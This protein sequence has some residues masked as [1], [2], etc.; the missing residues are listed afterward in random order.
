[1]TKFIY[2][3]VKILNINN[4]SF[5]LNYIYLIHILFKDSENIYF[6]SR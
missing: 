3:N 2:N 4:I 6:N 5:R 1:M